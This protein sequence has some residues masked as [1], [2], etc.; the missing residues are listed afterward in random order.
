[1]LVIGRDCYLCLGSW[2]RTSSSGKNLSSRMCQKIAEQGLAHSVTAFNSPYHDTGLFGVY[3]TAEPGRLD[4]L[5]FEV[6]SAWVRL[7]FEVCVSIVISCSPVLLSCRLFSFLSC[8]D[9]CVETRCPLSNC[10]GQRIS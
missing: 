5:M 8:F 4:D 10:N 1:M 3:A 7:C 6:M 9:Y 2:N